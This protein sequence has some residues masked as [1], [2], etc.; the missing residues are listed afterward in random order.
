MGPGLPGFA[1]GPGGA[2]Y[3]GMMGGPGMMGPPGI[4]GGPEG[5][6]MPGM[7]GGPASGGPEA[8][9]D[10]SQYE[11]TWWYHDKING[12]H[13]SFL[14]NKDGRLIQVQEYGHDKNHKGGKTR[15]GVGLGSN[16]AQ[17]LHTYGW[18]ND[19]AN[20]GRNMIMR[21]GGEDK[22]AFQLVNNVVVGITVAV[23]KDITPAEAPQ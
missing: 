1:G 15:L 16:L 17:I 7:S 13:K 22:I 3:P 20:E 23:V 5:M 14:F 19:A 18:S 9:E 6:A 10:Q 21:F 12:L 11:A 4:G 2:G 8:A